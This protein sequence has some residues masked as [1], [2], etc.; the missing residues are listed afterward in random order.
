MYS[1]G[2]LK[3]TEFWSYTFDDSMECLKL[4]P[5]LAGLI[6]TAKYDKNP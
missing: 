3:K 5:Q 6:Y 2:S 1:Q 4:L